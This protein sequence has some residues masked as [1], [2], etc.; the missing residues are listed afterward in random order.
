MQS[1]DDLESAEPQFLALS[2]SPA[3]VDIAAKRTSDGASQ[4]NAANT[5]SMPSTA[6]FRSSLKPYLSSSGDVLSSPSA[7]PEPRPSWMREVVSKSRAYVRECDLVA[8]ETLARENLLI[9]SSLDAFLAASSSVIGK[10]SSAD[11]FLLRAMSASGNAI[12]ELVHR[13]VASLQNLTIHRRDMALYGTGVRA[14]HLPK[15][16]HAPF[17]ARTTLFDPEVIRQVSEEEW[18]SA[19]KEAFTKALRASSM[20]PAQRKPSSHHAKQAPKRQAPSTTVASTPK[21]KRPKSS[22]PTPAPGYSGKTQ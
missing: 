21:A 18:E 2:S 22:V 17:L 10:N 20:P 6:S 14:P 9:L 8:L 19:K 15:L 3:I 5:G 13:T 11:P 7:Q 4:P 16:R 1:Q 12:A